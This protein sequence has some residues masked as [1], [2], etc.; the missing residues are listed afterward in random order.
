MKNLKGNMVTGPRE[1]M[2]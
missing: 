1:G 2:I